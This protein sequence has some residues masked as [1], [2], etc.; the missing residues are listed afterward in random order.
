MIYEAVTQAWK[1]KTTQ[2]FYAPFPA[3]EGKGRGEGVQE[4]KGG[5]RG[6]ALLPFAFFLTSQLVAFRSARN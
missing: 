5:R 1:T 3:I 2:V 6:P 4:G